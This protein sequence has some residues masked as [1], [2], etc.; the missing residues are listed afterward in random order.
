V[1]AAVG[2]PAYL[3]RDLWIPHAT[4]PPAPAGPVGLGINTVD[5][6]GQ[7]Q[8][9]WDRNSQA[10]LQGTRG[11]LNITSAGAVPQLV[12]LDHDHLASG[13]LTVARQSDHVDVSLSVTAPDGHTIREVTSFLGKLPER[14]PAKQE[15]TAPPQRQTQQTA[16]IAQ[17]RADLD[18]EVDRNRRLKRDVDFISK[19]LRDQARTRLMKQAPDKK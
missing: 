9:R 3:K 8:V 6:D 14:A 13:V 2:A 5:F 4:A 17:L 16:E 1:G 10:V 12:T 18:A 7:L 11:I 15:A 19:Q